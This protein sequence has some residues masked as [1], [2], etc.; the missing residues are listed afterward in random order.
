MQVSP[1]AWLSGLLVL[2]ACQVLGMTSSHRGVF[3]EAKPELMIGEPSGVA[4]DRGGNVYIADAQSDH[5]LKL[6][7]T[8]TLIATW[9]RAGR[10][11]GAFDHP[12][13]VAVNQR[14]VVYVADAGN[15]RIE[16]FTSSGKLRGAWTSSTFWGGHPT[17]FYALVPTLVLRLALDRIGHVFSLVPCLGCHR[18]LRLWEYSRAGV[19][20]RQ[21]D[22]RVQHQGSQPRLAPYVP[23]GIAVGPRGTV[24]ISFAAQGPSNKGTAAE[25][26]F[27]Q[28]RSPAGVVQAQWG[29]MNNETGDPNPPQGTGM[30]VMPSGN[31][32]VTDGGKHRIDEYMPNGKLVATW[33]AHGCGPGLFDI[34]AAIALDQQGNVY[35]A[36]KGNGTVQKLALDGK[37]ISLW[38]QCRS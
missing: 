3:A 20:L 29:G 18:A 38:G 31:L 27:I 16:S 26:F 2:A 15:G 12:S 23:L 1:R 25:F 4:V 11:P 17:G 36:D 35:V 34:P 30:A 10:A 6:S 21:W 8:G 7:M 22:T 37:P 13:G 32:L 33:G 28:R 9:G 19:L 14:G 5:V 24:Y